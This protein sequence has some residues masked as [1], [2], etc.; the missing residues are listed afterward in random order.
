MGE[1]EGVARERN[2]FFAVCEVGGEP[3]KCGAFNAHLVQPL[4]ENGAVT[5]IKL[6]VEVKKRWSF[7]SGHLESEPW[8]FPYHGEGKP[9]RRGSYR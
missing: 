1:G 7:R 9:G 5:C 8:Q 3:A 6:C 4:G 2:K